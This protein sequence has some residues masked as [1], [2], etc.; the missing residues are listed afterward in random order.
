M[1]SVRFWRSF[2]FFVLALV[3]VL[4]SAGQVVVRVYAKDYWELYERV[5]FKGTSIEI[6]GADLGKSYDLV[7]NRADLPLITNCGLRNEIIIDDL[8]T[9]RLEAAE[10]GFYCSY[11]SMKSILRNLALS[12]PFIC[13]L[14]SFG[15]THEG[16]FIL[17]LKIS[18]NPY[19]DE[20]EPEVLFMGQVHAREWAAGQVCRH[21]ADTLIRNY[22]T[23]SSFR[24]LIDNRE[25]WVFPIV[26]A[27]GFAYDYPGQRSWRK[28]RQPFSNF[29][30]P[31]CDDN[32]DFNGVCNGNRMAD[33]GSLVRGSRTTHLPTDET[34]FGAKGAWAKEIDALCN[35]FRQRTIVACIEFH[36]YSELILWPYGHGENTPD[37]AFYS[38]LGRQVAS[39][40]GKL[41]GGT[42]TPQRSDQLYPTNGGS[43]DW[44]YGWARTIGGFP[45]MSFCCE[46]GTSFYQ[47]TT[48]LNKIQTEAF[49][50][51][52]YLAQQAD[53]II[54]TLEGTVPRPILAPMDSSS[55]SFTVSWSP[56]RPDQNHPLKWELEELSDLTVLEDNMESGTDLWVLQGASRS[57]TQRRS[58]SYSIYLG[59][60]N[61]ISN[62]MMTKD[63]YPV[64]QGDSLRY[65][66][67]YNTEANYDVTVAEVSLEGK[68]W[69][70]LHERYTGN[71]SGWI[72]RAFSLE[73]WVGKSVFIRFRYMTDD[74][75][76]NPGVYVDDVWPVPSF[77]QR[78]VISDSI[79][80]TSFVITG[81]QVGTYY[82]RVRGYN[83][84]WGWG[85]KG[86]LEDIVVTGTDVRES[87]K[88]ASTVS[89]HLEPNPFRDRLV[90]RLTPR[91]KPSSPVSIYDA[92][93]REVAVL[94][95][96]SDSKGQE[97][98]W[99]GKDRSGR[100]VPA[101]VYYVRTRGSNA[102]Q[103]RVTCLR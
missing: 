79:T 72:R 39:R 25:I 7:C 30:P 23:N 22:A 35:W 33:W 16:R 44:F 36:S 60:G 97:L 64:R 78:M 61:N 68:E 19:V 76:L 51:S 75:T 69:F 83:A 77:G 37:S 13:R 43:D 2:L 57:T 28:N 52:F 82:Y 95:V 29:T 3:P 85:D 94:H 63:P 99:N 31:G 93:G 80:D 53:N 45:C 62:Y 101:G 18:D 8:D 71:S 46:L 67:W 21:I 50:G 92:T 55:G 40:I 89:V 54:A 103:F 100:Q 34:F 84:A 11:D 66:I 49:K 70:Q 6:A 9:R 17:G 88:G 59:T 4:A 20:D 26:N 14:D 98:I 12:Y 5:P 87:D 90:I 56:I 47:S 38:E 41:S 27:D 48:D 65:W 73:P 58:G 24:D 81:K 86:P 32:R 42:Y 96:S 91:A 1:Y 10:F 74:G 102:L 15:P